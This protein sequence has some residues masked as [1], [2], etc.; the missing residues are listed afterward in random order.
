MAWMKQDGPEQRWV[1]RYGNLVRLELYEYPGAI[2]GRETTHRVELW[3]GKQ[4]TEASTTCSMSQPSLEDAQ[5]AS[6][7]HA[8]HVLRQLSGAL[9]HQMGIVPGERRS[10]LDAPDA[11]ENATLRRKLVAME[12]RAVSAENLLRAIQEFAA[13]LPRDPESL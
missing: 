1:Y 13:G 12:K 4:A 7:K 9:E 2:S 11:L 6:L 3:F 8:V 5:L 10:R